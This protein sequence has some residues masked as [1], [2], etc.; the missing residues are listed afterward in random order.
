MNIA[1]LLS[2]VFCGIVVIYN[3]I[4]T[5]VFSSCYHTFSLFSFISILGI[6][7]SI[8]NHSLTNNIAKCIDRL[9]MT[10]SALYYFF[11]LTDIYVVLLSI[12]VL[13]FV[14]SK[15]TN[16]IVWHIMSHIVISSLNSWLVV[17]SCKKS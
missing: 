9:V 7:T 8:A 3:I 4:S 15:I 13:L 1:L 12:S 11:I 16:N 6:I 14:T 10:A 2:S 5:K 17:D